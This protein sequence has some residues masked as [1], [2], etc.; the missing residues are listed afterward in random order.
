M[1]LLN[2]TTWQLEGEEVNRIL[3]LCT[4]RRQSATSS[5]DPS[6]LVE[7]VSLD[8]LRTMS[9]IVLEAR[10]NEV[11]PEARSTL[12]FYMPCLETHSRAH[13]LLLHH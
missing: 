3:D 9:K 6:S 5:M 12:Y 4:D 8:Y 13:K 10:T 2:A 11:Q 7:E 1:C